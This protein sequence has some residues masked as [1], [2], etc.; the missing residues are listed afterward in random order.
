MDGLE[1]TYE[2]LAEA[3]SKPALFSAYT[4]DML[5]TDPHISE[6][7]L[8]YHLDGESGLSSCPFAVIDASVDC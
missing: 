5:W 7:M 4:A 2:L 1:A 3:L 8:S 6:R